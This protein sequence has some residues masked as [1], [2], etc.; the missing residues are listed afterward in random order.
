MSSPLGCPRCGFQNQPGYQFCVN[1][2][3][4][5][6][7]T[8]P[9]AVPVGA[10][11]YPAP[12]YAA[13]PA[14]VDYRRQEHIDR[15]K[16]GLLLL[17]IGAL[18]GWIPY[19]INLIGLVMSAIGAILVI[20]G[21]K[22]FGERHARFVVIAIILFVLSIVAA[23]ASG[24]AL[25]I[26]VASSVIGT[27]PTAASLETAVN[28]LLAGAIVSAVIGG[29]AQVLFTYAIQDQR[30]RVLL[31]AGYGAQVALQ[32]AIF[33][34]ISP[35]IA[36][37]VAAAFSGGTFSADPV[38]ALEAEITTYGIFVIVSDLLFAAAY[39]VA[40]SRVSRGLIPEKLAGPGPTFPPAAAP[41]SG[42]A[43]PI[44]PR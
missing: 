8:P 31:F 11:A 40:W 38:I 22:A 25:A 27:T 5:L 43:P 15:T 23:F 26:V 37:V 34:I 35:L 44:N 13:P 4:P 1:C 30:G 14:A 39:Y 36:S 29:L 33:V 16:T 32:A 17:M 42:P 7:T 19:E 28:V 12:V 10:G 18:L 3:A 20:L 9:S 24:I 41:P 2:G 21:R 6:T